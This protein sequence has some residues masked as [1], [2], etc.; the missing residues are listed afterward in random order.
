MD[1]IVVHGKSQDFLSRPKFGY[2][3]CDLGVIGLFVYSNV[4]FTLWAE[5]A[6]RLCKVI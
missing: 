2:F 6:S 3:R 5:F 4:C 1:P